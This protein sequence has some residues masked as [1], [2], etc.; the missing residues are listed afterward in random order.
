MGL[1]G[2]FTCANCGRTFRGISW[3]IKNG[4][5][6]CGECYDELSKESPYEEWKKK[7]MTQLREERS[8][9][10]RLEAQSAC[11]YCGKTFDMWDIYKLVLKDKSQICYECME[12]LRVGFPVFCT[13]EKKSSTGEFVPA[14]DDPLKELTLA[15]IPAAMTFAEEERTRRL[16][17][18][19]AH[20]GVFVVDDVVRSKDQNG[21]ELHTIWGRQ[22]LG[23]V[24]GGDVLCVRRREMPYFI[25]VSKVVQQKF[26]DKAKSLNEGHDGGLEVPGDVSF[27]YPGD[28]LTADAKGGAEDGR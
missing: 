2:P 27:I 26:N 13:E 6:V 7:T 12:K 20:K 10:A 4:K 14:F 25:E 3:D 8:E 21:Q 1:F 18:Y 11:S 17:K 16:K 5:V 28:I 24:I 9:K 15:D 22:V 23:S 19:G